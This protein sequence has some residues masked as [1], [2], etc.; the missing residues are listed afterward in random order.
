M[1][2]DEGKTDSLLIDEQK[3]DSL[4]VPKGQN[5]DSLVLSGEQ[6]GYPLPEQKKS[7]LLSNQQKTDSLMVLEDQTRDS[8]VIS[9]E[10]I[11]VSLIPTKEQT[12]DSESLRNARWMSKLPSHLTKIPLNRLAIPGSHN[13]GAYSLDP[14]TPMSPG[15]VEQLLPVLLLARF[16]VQ[17]E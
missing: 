14:T 4:L 2:S 17:I 1:A 16:L 15:R 5:G 7:S 11:E 6:K 8:L 13:S 12:E 3:E 10:K 9:G